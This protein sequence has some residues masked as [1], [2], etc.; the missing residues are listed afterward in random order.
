MRANR[1][2]EYS[3]PTHVRVYVYICVFV[4]F[5]QSMKIDCWRQLSIATL[6]L[7]RHVVTDSHTAVQTHKHARTRD[8][9]P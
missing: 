8:R 1:V 5:L 6:V 3:M 2:H 4:L 9:L 7:I